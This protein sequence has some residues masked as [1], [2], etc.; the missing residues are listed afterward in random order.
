MTLRAKTDTLHCRKTLHSA[1]LFLGPGA[2]GGKAAM[3]LAALRIAKLLRLQ[4]Q[5]RALAT[6]AACQIPVI[7]TDVL[8]ITEHCPP[9]RLRIA[10]HVTS[11]TA[12]SRE[13]HDG[14]LNKPR[15]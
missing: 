9:R 10:L 2:F 7:S 1:S 11:V 8:V 13:T 4:L 15:S 5:H 6:R 14:D 3:A 12:P